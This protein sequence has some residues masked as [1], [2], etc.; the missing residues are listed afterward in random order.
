MPKAAKKGYGEYLEAIDPQG[1]VANREVTNLP[2]QFL[3]RGSK[4]W[5]VKKKEKVV[6]RGGCSYLGDSHTMNYGIV[7]AFDW[8][9]STNVKRSVRH[10]YKRLEVWYADAW[11]KIADDLPLS[12]LSNYTTVWMAGEGIDGMIM[13]LGDDIIRMWSGGIAKI[14]SVTA[15]TLTK[16]EYVAGTDIEFNDNGASPDTIEKAGGGFT[17]ADFQVGQTLIVTGSASNNGSY[18]IAAV[19]DTV[20]TLSVDDELTT[21]AAGASV[22]LKTP[23]GTWASCR[24]LTTG[25]RSVFIEG[26]KYVYTGGENTGTLTGLVVSPVG[27]VDAGD[28]GFQGLVESS[29]ATLTDAEID[30]VG[31][32]NNHI[33]YGSTKDRIVQISADDDYTD[34]TQSDPRAPGEG[35]EFVGDAPPTGFAIDGLSLVIT[36]GE[37]FW[38]EVFTELSAD[39][40]TESI[41]IKRYQ[42]A[43]GQAAVSQGAIVPIK[44]TTAYLSVEGS[45]DTL[46]NLERLN[47]EQGQ[48]PISDDI[49]D[50]LM[51][52]DRSGADGK[53]FSN[54]L[55]Y[56]LPREA[57]IIVYDIQDGFWQ[58]PQTFPPISK[59]AII[60]VDGV[61]RLCGHA[62]NSNETYILFE[63]LNDL[64]GPIDH[65]AA[66]GYDNFG[67]RFQAKNADEFALEAYITR[68]TILK[69]RVLYDFEGATDAREFAISDQYESDRFT[70]RTTVHLG[71]NRFG[72]NPFG[73]SV[74]EISNITKIRTVNTTSAL[75]FYERAR[76]FRTDEID[77]YAEI[78]AYGENAQ[79]SENEPAFIH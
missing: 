41:R 60:E 32:F 37:D 57:V 28:Y 31:A 77:S 46:T 75:D 50:D 69:D 65:I 64:G 30:L 79:L 8:V 21:E 62:A 49:K 66:F 4:N 9:T 48:K 58:P 33:A 54:A 2:G 19:T 51:E 7:G 63:G 11:R 45:I 39:Q 67:H 35:F 22:V 74:T 40:G 25:T 6:T 12:R 3:I 71:S 72:Y 68:N 13:A 76:V 52:Y 10:Y 24:F 18:T 5:L 14:A 26:I 23:N 17:L 56:T 20:I 27:N 43:A 44:Q 34:F 36:C 16:T 42:T 53:Y 29:P 47:T 61:R 73:S 59:L 70:P 15:N 78:L 1:Y 38:Y 55:F